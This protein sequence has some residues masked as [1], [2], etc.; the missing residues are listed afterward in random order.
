MYWW[1]LWECA[2]FVI[3]A[4]FFACVPTSRVSWNQSPALGHFHWN[5]FNGSIIV[6]IFASVIQ[7]MISSLWHIGSISIPNIRHPFF[8]ISMQALKFISIHIVLRVL[9]I[10]KLFWW[11]QIIQF[12]FVSNCVVDFIVLLFQM[13]RV[14]QQQQISIHYGRWGVFFASRCSLPLQTHTH[15]GH[16]VSLFVRA[17]ECVRALLVHLRSQSLA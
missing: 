12:H 1:W 4:D 17:C 13:Q 2:N 11:N 14:R 3:S 10:G 7:A 6:I 9:S 8:P 15:T 16:L 5:S